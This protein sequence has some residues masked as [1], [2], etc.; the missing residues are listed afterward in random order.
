MNS[1]LVRDLWSSLFFLDLNMDDS[2]DTDLSETLSVVDGESSPR[3]TDTSMEEELNTSSSS[4][5]GKKR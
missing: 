4:Q 5:L 1:C 2:L 3:H